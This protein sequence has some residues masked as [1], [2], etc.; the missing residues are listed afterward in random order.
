METKVG[1][2]VIYDTLKK[3]I[4]NKVFVPGSLLPTELEMAK[5]Y[6]VS[7]PTV[8]KVYNMLQKEGYVK[9]KIGSGT[10]VVYGNTKSKYVFGLLLPG[11]GE[12]EIFS[13]INDQLLKLSREAKFTC[14]WDGATASSAEIRRELIESNCESYI[15]Q[16]VNGIFFSPLERVSNADVINQ[17]IC[18][19]TADAGIPIV[20]IDR[21]IVAF[22]ERSKFD[23]VS[24]D[25]LTAGYIMANH[26]CE[27]GCTTLYF[28]YR[29]DSAYSVLKRISGIIMAANQYKLS[30]NDDNL[31]SGE[32]NDIELVKRR[33]QIKSGK[34]GIVCANDATAA[35]LASSLDVSGSRIGQDII[36]CGFD[37]MKYAEHLKFP[38]TSYQQPCKEIADEAVDV[39][40]KRI[41]H[42]QYATLSVSLVGDIVVRESTKF[43]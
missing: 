26:L 31:V 14:L 17:M 12:S 30:F 25:H 39:M 35:L 27:A 1:S 4:E 29:P 13:I 34:T 3:G 16:K 38:L 7:R 32:P 15:R 42:P 33:I 8:A 6:S 37:N 24:L 22:P 11:A 2:K 20:L 28:F 9:K 40:M 43:I 18:K 10:M 23:L 41:N 19:K 5:K 21:D 36:I